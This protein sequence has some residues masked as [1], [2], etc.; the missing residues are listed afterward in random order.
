MKIP[1]A[2]KSKKLL[3]V[4][5]I[6]ALAAAFAVWWTMFRV[7]PETAATDQAVKEKLDAF[8]LA[9]GEEEEE[10]FADLEDELKAAE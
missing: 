2:K 7:D 9:E 8:D 6:A 1:M 10:D 3:L 5:L 4:G